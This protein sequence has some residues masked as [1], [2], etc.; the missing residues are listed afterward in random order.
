M[1]MFIIKRE[2]ASWVNWFYEI[3][4]DNKDDALD[5]LFE[6]G[7]ESTGHYIG[8]ALETCDSQEEFIDTSD[9]YY[10]I[11]SHGRSTVVTSDQLEAAR[12]YLSD[13]CEMHLKSHGKWSLDTGKM[14]S[15]LESCGILVE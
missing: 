2:V 12:K 1:A 6:G 7:E 10:S 3:E 11:K 9:F 15:A 5:K 14:T 4:A 13:D 8:D